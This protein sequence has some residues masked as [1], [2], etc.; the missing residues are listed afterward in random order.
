MLDLKKI[1]DVTSQGK[2]ILTLCGVP[3][4]ALANPGKKAFRWLRQNERTPSAFVYGPDSRS[5]YWRVVDYGNDRRT[6]KPIDAY[7]LVHGIPQ[8][9]FGRAVAEVAAK[10]NI[11]DELSP[12]VNRPE[13]YDRPAK[14]TEQEG[15]RYFETR[16][17]FTPTEVS[18]WGK[19]VTADTLRDY[20][21]HAAVW[22]GT[23]KEG[24]VKERHSNDSYPIF[25]KTCPY[26]DRDGNDEVF[27]KVYEPFNADKKFRFSTI[28]NVPQDYIFGMDFVKRLVATNNDQK[29]DRVCIVSGGS[30]AIN[31]WAMG[32]PAVYFNSETAMMTM[33]QYSTIMQYTKN[34]I[35]IP[36]LDSTG[37][38]VGKTLALAFPL[39]ATAWLPET[40]LKAFRDNRGR[41]C[42]DLKDY[43][44]VY[45]TKK[46]FKD[47]LRSARQ[48]QFWNAQKDKDDNVVKYYL[49]PTN[50]NYF[51]E[52][53]G[54]YTLA[55]VIHEKPRYIHID[56]TVVEDVMA[57]DISNFINNWAKEHGLSE[58]LQNVILRSK[59]K[60]NKEHSNLT[61]RNLN[62]STATQTSQLYFFRNGWIEVTAEG[63]HQHRYFESPATECFVWKDCII[64]HD[65]RVFRPM[66]EVTE[67]GEGTYAISIRDDA[68][69]DVLRYLCQTSRLY[70]RQE[71]E[72]GMKL[73]P[74]QHAEEMQCLVAKIAVIGFLLHKFK[75]DALALAVILQDA[76][77]AENERDCNGRSGKSFFIKFLRLLLN[78]FDIDGRNPDVTKN[79][80]LFDGVTE[81]TDIVAVDECAFNLDY[82][83]FFGRITGGFCIEEKNNHQFEI[84]FD[85][86]P[87]IV[88][89]SNYVIKHPDSSTEAR[90]WTQV[91]GD[92][93]HQKAKNNDYLETRSIRDDFGYNLL[94][95]AYPEDKWSADIAFAMQCLQFY[96]SLPVEKRKVMPPLGTIEKRTQRAVMGVNFEEWASAY[97][98]EGSEH[99]DRLE[100]Y[101]TVYKDF[102]NTTGDKFLKQNRFT[103]KLKEFCDFADHIAC[104]NPMDVTGKPKDGER[105]RV[106]EDGVLVSKLYIRSKVEA[107]E[108]SAKAPEQQELFDDVQ[109]F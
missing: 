68:E 105:Y 65:Y 40:K 73:T 21:W 33:D 87:K 9:E 2:D 57:K 109:P 38:R 84:P 32:V 5:E 95:A 106:R 74:E 50:L 80:F 61:E 54:Y 19:G 28:G 90:M 55:D 12:K 25:I 81:A 88:F 82:R 13:W 36:D 43:R 63:I 72:Q 71:Y 85:K 91:F 108:K 30:D 67:T 48:A 66:F 62:F 35:N 59:D 18:L 98:E 4:E 49:S 51:L 78:Y 83:F 69:S 29:L 10:L 1:L 102:Q 94:G 75:D 53:H 23:V 22:V 42:K 6:Y 8:S 34:L 46:D 47:L 64:K 26:R 58:R 93:Y 86:S 11:T 3:E 7:M 70:W 96:L 37:I 79:K 60:P 14:D 103:M 15:E 44:N 39:M 99:L 97:Y 101:D 92:Y 41:Q 77:L 27:Y 31:C 76:F 17:T 107:E 45:P 100:N 52:L 16:D 104:L 24:K 56:G 89:A 20:G